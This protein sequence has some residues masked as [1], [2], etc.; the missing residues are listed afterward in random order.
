MELKLL[1]KFGS[2][3]KEEEFDDRIKHRYGKTIGHISHTLYGVISKLSYELN[4]YVYEL[5]SQSVANFVLSNYYKDDLYGILK[6]IENSKRE[7]LWYIL[8]KGKDLTITQAGENIEALPFDYMNVQMVLEELICNK[9]SGEIIYD[10]VSNEY[11]E[12][13][14]E[15]KDKWKERLEFIEIIG[16]ANVCFE[17]DDWG[18]EKEK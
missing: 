2:D 18:D 17:E 15:D 4:I 16:N 3:I 7:L 11:D 5:S 13:V 6:E 14:A 10:F 9:N 8:K 1:Q 12:Q